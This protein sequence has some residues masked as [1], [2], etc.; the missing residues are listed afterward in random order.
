MLTTDIGAR[1]IQAKYTWKSEMEFVDDTGHWGHGVIDTMRTAGHSPMPVMFHGSPIDPRFRNKR[2][3]M[4]VRMSEWIKAGG[5]IPNIPEL[6]GELTTPTYTFLNGKMIMEDKDLIKKRL[7]R[8]PDLADALALTFALPDAP[9]SGSGIPLFD[10]HGQ[11]KSD[12]DPIH[13]S[14]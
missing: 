6:I 13:R 9:M 14:Y 10:G 5:A 8:S 12:Y 4:W 7:G 11:M 2:C 3:E 1:V